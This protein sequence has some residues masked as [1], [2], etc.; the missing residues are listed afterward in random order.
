MVYSCSPDM[1][2]ELFI[3]LLVNT[4]PVVSLA[5][6]GVGSPQ[7]KEESHPRTSRGWV[8]IYYHIRYIHAGFHSLVHHLTSDAH[9]CDK[10][11]LSIFIG[12][13]YTL[14]TRDAA[15]T[16]QTESC[17]HGASVL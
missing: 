14:G 3:W 17:P 15:Q 2:T 16:E 4:S 13:S 6:P 10:T 5:L 9:S 11:V 1:N 8:H 7:G 12:S